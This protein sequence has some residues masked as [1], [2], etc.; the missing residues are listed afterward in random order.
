[1]LA[2][3]QALAGAAEWLL[4]SDNAPGLDAAARLVPPALRLPVSVHET[5][6]RADHYRHRGYSVDQATPNWPICPWE[7]C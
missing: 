5:W 4:V 1:M 2:V 6:Q 7:Q 3:P